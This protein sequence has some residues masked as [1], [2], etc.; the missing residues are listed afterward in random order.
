[1]K[2]LQKIKN[3]LARDRKTLKALSFR[4]KIRFIT[5]YYRGYAFVL[6]CLC[7]T[8][9]FVGEAWM[10]T[11]RETVLEGF[12]TNDEENLYP[13]GSITRDFSSFLG[14]SSNQQVIFDD[15]LYVLP[16]SSVD[17]HTA[18]HGKIMAYVSARELDFLVTTREL[19]E[20]YGKVFP[21]LDLEQFL[22]DG[23]AAILEDHLYYIQDSDGMTRPKALSLEG[24]RFEKR[25]APSSDDPHYL[26]VLSYTDHQEAMIRFLEYAFED[27]LAAGP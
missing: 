19:A 17:Y 5:D 21:L 16:G 15:S 7:L 25:A 4:Q 3:D 9:L 24:S 20:Y 8:G 26:I 12:F 10:Q 14:L 13:A 6:I 2:F 1:M 22:P 23:L 27:S 11:R 18:S